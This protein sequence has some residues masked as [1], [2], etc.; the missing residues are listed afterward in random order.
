MPVVRQAFRKTFQGLMEA[1]ELTEDERETLTEMALAMMNVEE[2]LGELFS[3]FY[4]RQK[5]HQKQYL[6]VAWLC[7]AYLRLK[8]E[9]AL[10]NSP[11]LSVSASSQSF[12]E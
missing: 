2:L 10:G 5:T 4:T 6:Y 11:K 7:W 12:R 1:E 9:E 8:M 3:G